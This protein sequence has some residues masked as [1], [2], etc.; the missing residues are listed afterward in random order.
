MIL[1]LKTNN[2]LFKIL[3]SILMVHFMASCDEPDCIP[4]YEFTLIGEHYNLTPDPLEEEY[5]GMT[6]S[7]YNMDSLTQSNYNF[8]DPLMEEREYL[9]YMEVN[10]LLFNSNEFTI[11]YDHPDSLVLTGTMNPL[12]YDIYDSLYKV[13]TPFFTISRPSTR[14]ELNF[15]NGKKGYIAVFDKIWESNCPLSFTGPYTRLYEYRY[16][17]RDNTK[18]REVFKVTLDSESETTNGCP[19]KIGGCIG[20]SI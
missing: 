18:Y 14:Y 11:K 2:I 12:T 7:I 17:V 5:R 13:F 19:H 16:Y 10:L 6:I 4:Q 1:I 15:Y 8:L 3:W 9:P 20:I